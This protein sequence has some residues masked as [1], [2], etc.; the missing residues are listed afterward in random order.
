[1]GSRASSVLGTVSTFPW[2]GY[3]APG[4]APLNQPSSF[5]AI[6]AV[7][8]VPTAPTTSEATAYSAVAA[9]VG[10]GADA[11][12][13]NSPACPDPFNGS[14]QQCLLQAGTISIEGSA[15]E[16]PPRYDW[17]WEDFPLVEHDN[18]CIKGCPPL[19]G[20]D[21]VDTYLQYFGG[22]QA[23]VLFINETQGFVASAS[24]ITP[25]LY[26]NVEASAE[27]I[28]EPQQGNA[29]WSFAPINFSNLTVYANRQGANC[30]CTGF[31]GALSVFNLYKYYTPT[32]GC[33]GP[34]TEIPPGDRFTVT[35]T[36]ASSCP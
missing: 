32:Y 3:S 15:V 29:R 2:V 20:G 11:S 7:W 14:P 4:T 22:N 19:Q 24:A 23:S 1:M 9:W 26:T 25:T 31:G 17:F 16:G 30:Q 8:N 13:P 27:A 5:T 18:E 35:Y 36:T 10:L 34:I 28:V 21:Q 6:Q 12:V 33:A